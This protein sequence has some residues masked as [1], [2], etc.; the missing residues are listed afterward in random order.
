MSNH[1]KKTNIKTFINPS[2]FLVHEGS[3]LIEFTDDADT[4]KVSNTDIAYIDGQILHVHDG[5]V[6]EYR[7][8]IQCVL[9]EYEFNWGYQHIRCIKDGSGELLW[10]ND[11]YRGD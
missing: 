8:G 6:E 10:V 1:Q 3:F 7:G 2:D 9:N 5:Q 4:N 11:Y